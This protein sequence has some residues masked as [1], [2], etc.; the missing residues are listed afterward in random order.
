MKKGFQIF[1][2][3]C[4]AILTIYGLV[5]GIQQITNR[6]PKEVSQ[7]ELMIYLQQ[8]APVAQNIGESIQ[9][10]APVYNQKPAANE[11]QKK[12]VLHQLAQT[13]NQFKGFSKR[14][15]QVSPPQAIKEFHEQVRHSIEGY[16]QA[17]G[18]TRQGFE[19]D[20]VKMIDEGASLLEKSS[21]QL[22][23]AS[24]EIARTSTK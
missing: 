6:A 17:F 16:L 9:K 21:A 2:G 11:N 24:Q 22:N 5:Q 19:Q 20:N 23:D 10:I 15:E 8:L 7:Q 3:I 18:M 4:A 12:A 13:E 14:M 1:V